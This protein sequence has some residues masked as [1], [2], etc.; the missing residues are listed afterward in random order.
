[1]SIEDG[2]RI[3]SPLRAKVSHRVAPFVVVSNAGTHIERIE[4]YCATLKSARECVSCYDDPC[5]V[6]RVLPSGRLTTEI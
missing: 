5:E 3:D 4:D 2:E 6:M 1:M